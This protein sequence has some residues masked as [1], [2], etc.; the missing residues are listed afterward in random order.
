MTNADSADGPDVFSVPGND[1][2]LAYGDGVFETLATV[3]GVTRFTEMHLDRLV[4]GATALGIA[5]PDLETIRE[6]LVRAAQDIPGHGW[7]KLLITRGAGGRGYRPTGSEVP[8]VLVSSGE[9]KPGPARWRV[10]I[11]EQ[12]VAD[13]GVLNGLKH[14]NRLPQ[15]LAARE[16][17]TEEDE[18]LM[19]D[20]VGALACGTMT[21]V[22]LVRDDTILTPDQRQVAVRGVMREFVLR[23][24][25]SGRVPMVRPTSDPI[26][27]ADLFS[28]DEVFVTNAVRGVVS[29][30]LVD[31]RR[32]PETTPIADALRDQLHQVMPA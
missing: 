27:P 2:G 16:L 20:A 18:G 19:L 10:K 1:R 28:A 5:L 11:C 13:L 21:N 9:L 12:R 22:F 8:N 32:L 14:L 26:W 15:V 3:N 25:Q 31:G 24:G 29:V 4:R 30:Q 6:R 7:V 17:T 23:A